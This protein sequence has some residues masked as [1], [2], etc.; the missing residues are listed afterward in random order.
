M[1]EQAHTPGP[2]QQEGL[3]IVVF[4]R[5]IIAECPTPQN[6]GTFDCS[7]NAAFIVRACNAHD[8]LVAALDLVCR[9]QRSGALPTSI[10]NAITAAIVKA[11]GA[12]PLQRMQAAAKA[13]AGQT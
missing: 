9:D 8:D 13:T 4:G 11:T 2:W 5:G 7:A 3:T 1:T 12:T 10:Q 6:G